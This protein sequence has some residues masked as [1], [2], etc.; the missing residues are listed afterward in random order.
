MQDGEL[1]IATRG[2]LV[3]YVLQRYQIDPNTVLANAAAQQTVSGMF[4]AYESAHG[5][6][7]TDAC[8]TVGPSHR[9]GC[10][11]LEVCQFIIAAHTWRL[12]CCCDSLAE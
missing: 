8:A 5:Y 6:F 10:R 7:R 12:I 11:G 9:T 4:H 3:Q 1:R 2:A